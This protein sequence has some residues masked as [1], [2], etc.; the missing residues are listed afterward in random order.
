M[1]YL[2][3]VILILLGVCVWV[4]KQALQY[5]S[6]LRKEVLD[7]YDLTR[8][9]RDKVKSVYQLEMFYGDPH[10]KDLVTSSN[11]FLE[12]LRIIKKSFTTA[13]VEEDEEEE[14]NGEENINKQ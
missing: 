10:L 1:G 6:A 5:T 12:E 11:L 2:T 8:E 7:L 9:Y 3:I 4:I 14:N 13:D